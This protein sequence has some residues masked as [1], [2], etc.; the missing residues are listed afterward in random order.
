M[1]KFVLFVSLS[2]CAH[3]ITSCSVGPG[4][5]PYF[6]GIPVHDPPNDNSPGDSDQVEPYEVVDVPYFVDG[7]VYYYQH[8]GRYYYTAHGHRHYVSNLPASGRRWNHRDGHPPQYP[9]G[10]PQRPR[11]VQNGLPRNYTLPGNHRRDTAPPKSQTT[12]GLPPTFSPRNP[13]SI[14]PQ[15]Q[16]PLGHAP[17]LDH[18]SYDGGHSAQQQPQAQPAPAPAKGQQN[19]TPGNGK[20]DKDNARSH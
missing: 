18:R 15:M 12:N 11:Q 6:L 5:A 19:A 17:Q 9:T 3:L 1:K 20:N 2:T 16:R 4:G 8:Q 14:T 10:G 7:D 13:G